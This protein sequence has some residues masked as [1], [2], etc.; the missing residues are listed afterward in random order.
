VEF[1]IFKWREVDMTKEEFREDILWHY[2][3]KI[4]EYVIMVYVSPFEEWLIDKLWDACKY[5]SEPEDNKE[6]FTCHFCKIKNDCLY[7]WDGYN[8]LPDC[9]GDK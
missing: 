9:L 7:A 1:V 8:I 2:A 6:E 3:R 4:N 5:S